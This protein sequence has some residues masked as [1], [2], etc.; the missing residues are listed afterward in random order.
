MRMRLNSDEFAPQLMALNSDAVAVKMKATTG[1]FQVYRVKLADIVV[2]QSEAVFCRNYTTTL[3]S[4][5]THPQ[6]IC[7]TSSGECSRA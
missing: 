6:S 5:L 3:Q 1:G 7:K 2:A 4:W